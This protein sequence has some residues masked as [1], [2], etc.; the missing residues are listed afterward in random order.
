M[1]KIQLVK[2]KKCK[3]SVNEFQ[4]II[5]SVT[6][7]VKIEVLEQNHDFP[8]RLLNDKTPKKYYEELEGQI[9][10]DALLLLTDVPYED[11]YF[12]HEYKKVAIISFYGWTYLTPSLPKENGLLYWVCVVAYSFVQTKYI[13]HGESTGCL[14]DFLADKTGID[15]CMRQASLCQDCLSKLKRKK[16]SKT[17]KDILKDTTIL[18]DLLSQKSRWNKSILSREKDDSNEISISTRITNKAGEVKIFIASPSDTQKERE[19]LLH[20]LESKFRTY[21]FEES[22]G[23]RVITFGWEDLASQSGYAQDIINEQILRNVDIVL[24]ILKHKLGTPTKNKKG[25]IRAESG[26]AE[27]LY[28]ALE[29]NPEKVLCMLYVFSKPPSPSFEDSNYKS[30]KKD[31]DN[32]Q[33]F[34][35]KIQDKVLYKIYS[36]EEELLNLATLDLNKNIKT[37]FSKTKKKP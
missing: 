23:Y 3:I 35:S 24:G 15:L 11:N 7:S 8:E 16:L 4:R 5:N 6:R 2:D 37:Y 19:I 34:K 13:G 1:L 32:V 36:S 20:Q 27:E 26:T 9:N 33:K 31:W 21:G 10:G 30:I 25:K 17:Q 22:V 29:K 14:N 28:Y 12:L 18:L